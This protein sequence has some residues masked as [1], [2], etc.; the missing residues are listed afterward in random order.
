MTMPN[1]LKD[2]FSDVRTEERISWFI[3]LSLALITIFSILYKADWILGDNYTFI[4]TTGRGKTVPFLNGTNIG[5]T[6]FF[7]FAGLD[8]NIL[9]FIPGASS[10]FAHYLYVAFSFIVFI[11]F[12]VLSSLEICAQFNI[13]HKMYFSALTVFTA[14]ACRGFFE[15]YM[16]VIFAER[17]ITALLSVFIFCIIRAAANDKIR[18][19]IIAFLCAFIATYCKETV[20]A[21]FFV[22]ACWTLIFIKEKSKRT[23]IFCYSLLANSVLFLVLYYIFAWNGIGGG[24]YRSDSVMGVWD[25]LLDVFKNSP[26]LLFVFIFA[27]VRLAQCVLFRQKSIAVADPILMSSAVFA[28][29]YFVLRYNS[30][31][32][33]APAMTVGAIPVVY[34]AFN[35]L[36]KYRKTGAVLVILLGCLNVCTIPSIYDAVSTVIIERMRVI[37]SLRKIS[38]LQQNGGNIYWYNAEA[39][40]ENIYNITNLYLN[41]IQNTEDKNF[42]I[43]TKY[44]PLLKENDVFLYVVFD[45]SDSMKADVRVIRFLKE[46]N[47]NFYQFQTGFLVFMHERNLK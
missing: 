47:F 23:K 36:N 4:L 42:L 44:L 10:A 14:L 29:E 21:L 33:Y 7:P 20:F 2:F 15:S 32:Y 11:V 34:F 9:A 24:M 6:R 43:K 13:R 35:M 17:A 46:S 27:L 22:Y 3:I 12:L 41:F 38:S 28:L 26:A 18:Y 25:M 30:S 45:N 31:Y 1:S 39:E 8:F 37:P 40:Q 19:Y 16:N 5:S